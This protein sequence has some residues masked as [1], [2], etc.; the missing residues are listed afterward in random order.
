MTMTTTY[1][2]DLHYRIM[3][4]PEWREWCKLISDPDSSRKYSYDSLRR[5]DISSTA[6]EFARKIGGSDREM[7]LADAAGLLYDCGLICEG[8]AYH[9]N[10]A[11]IARPFLRVRWGKNNPLNHEDIETICNAIENPYT[12]KESLDCRESQNKV[13]LAFWFAHSIAINQRYLKDRSWFGSANYPVRTDYELTDQEL[14]IIFTVSDRSITLGDIT[15]HSSN[16][17]KTLEAVAAILGKTIDFSVVM[18]E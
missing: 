13:Q 14:R 9:K 16:E 2:K 11:R 17:I 3:N 1:F 8:N 7:Y 10:S 18:A 6:R 5:H 4:D 15:F 12:F